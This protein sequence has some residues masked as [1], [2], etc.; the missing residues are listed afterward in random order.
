MC[1]THHKDDN[2]FLSKVIDKIT[3][4]RE[5]TEMNEKRAQSIKLEWPILK[6]HPL[7]VELMSG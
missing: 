1:D 6:N 3:S 4:L 2:H 7:L 5:L